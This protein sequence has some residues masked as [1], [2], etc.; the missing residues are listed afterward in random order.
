MSHKPILEFFA[1]YIEDELGI[2]YAETNHFQLQ[3]RLEEIATLLGVKDLG[4][5]HALA[6]QGIQGQF[7]ELL[8]DLATNNETSFFRDPKVFRAIES[9]V[10]K[11]ADRLRI[12]SAAASTGQ[13]ALSVAILIEEYNFK[14]KPGVR[15]SILGTDISERALQR[16]KA[17]VYSQ[18][19]VQRGLPAPHLIKYFR[20]EGADKWSSIPE[21]KS[22]LEF[23]KINL[24]KPF[25]FPEPFELI[26]CRN[27]L[28]YQ[29]PERKKEILD[30]ITAALAPGGYLV[31]GSGESLLG[32]SNDYVRCDADGAII[33]RKK[34]AHDQGD[35]LASVLT[36]QASGF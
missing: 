27:M 24:T 9:I 21:L 7:R 14:M 17:G 22:R 36:Q 34:P 13:E 33:Y 6:R 11:A 29:N 5:L 30:R 2:V 18:L 25:S 15:Y 20:K 8:L 31:L 28:I 10:L 19:E 16:A 35:K 4:E 12:W 32:L 3:H 26:L 1:K 23:R